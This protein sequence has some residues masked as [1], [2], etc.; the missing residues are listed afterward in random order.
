MRLINYY[1]I[2]IINKDWKDLFKYMLIVL[3]IFIFLY[4]F[5]Q[6]LV[7]DIES[8]MNNR[9]TCNYCFITF[10]NIDELLYHVDNYHGRSKPYQRAL[11]FLFNNILINNIINI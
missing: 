5:N 11:S 3:I 7:L 1:I 10:D 4:F 2:S 6:L 8:Y 9:P